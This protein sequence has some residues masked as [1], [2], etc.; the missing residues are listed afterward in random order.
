VLAVQTFQ[1]YHGLPMDGI[2]GQETMKLIY[3]A[4]AMTATVGKANN[5]TKMTVSPS[6]NPGTTTPNPGAS[7]S[8]STSPTTNP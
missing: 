1:E 3:S 2:A 6:A 5:K 8:P 4:E 7:T